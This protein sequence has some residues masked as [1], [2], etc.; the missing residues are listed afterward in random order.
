MSDD[1]RLSEKE[2]KFIDRITPLEYDS[3]HEEERRRRAKDNWDTLVRE[4]S[5]KDFGLIKER[6]VDAL[7]REHRYRD[8]KGIADVDL[9]YLTGVH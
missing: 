6:L 4:Y 5:P 8:K 7:K 1:T 2:K 9:S 3:L